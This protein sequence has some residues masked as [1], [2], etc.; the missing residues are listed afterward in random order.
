MGVLNTNRYSNVPTVF[1]PLTNG[2]I[3]VIKWGH[4]IITG[5]KKEVLFVCANNKLFYY[6]VN[7]AD[8]DAV[9]ITGI[10][11][12]SSVHTSDEYLFVGT[13]DGHVQILDLANE[14]TVSRNYHMVLNI[15]VNFIIQRRKFGQQVFPKHT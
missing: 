8:S 15:N 1:A 13:R 9:E 4:V 10:Q 7:S 12:V 2:V 6:K 11:N 3:Y 5:V 14:F